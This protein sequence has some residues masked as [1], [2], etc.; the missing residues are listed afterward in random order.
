V[1]SGCIVTIYHH[2]ALEGLRPGPPG[3]PDPHNLGLRAPILGLSALLNGNKR[4]MVRRYSTYPTSAVFPFGGYSF[5]MVEVGFGGT[6]T[7]SGVATCPHGQAKARPAQ[8]E[9]RL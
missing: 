9:A 2:S 6:T 3:A 7:A 5:N 1:V 8:I 4:G